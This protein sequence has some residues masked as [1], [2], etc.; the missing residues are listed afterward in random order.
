VELSVGT[1]LWAVWGQIALAQARAAAEARAL[2]VAHVEAGEP[3]DSNLELWPSMLAIVAAVTSVDGFAA[4]I[5]EAGVLVPEAD[6]P[7]RASWV[8][9]LLRE[10][11]EVTSKTNEWPA[12]MKDLY[13]LRSGRAV[14]GLLHPKTLFGSAIDHPIVPGVA[15]ARA[16]YTVERVEQAIGLMRDVYGTCRGRARNQ[17]PALVSRM[18]G[19]D[20]LLA[21]LQRL[22]PL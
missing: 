8:W 3:A 16:L 4:L 17:H 1:E 12:A 15:P 21:T 19:L 7:T 22:S 14:G 13:V 10:G 9:A 6:Y 11:F 2:L 18:S 20:G 5:T